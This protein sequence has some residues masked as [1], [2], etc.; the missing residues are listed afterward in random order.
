MICVIVLQITT[1]WQHIE[2]RTIIAG[3]KYKMW[4]WVCYSGPC[5]WWGGRNKTGGGGEWS[6]GGCWHTLGHWDMLHGVHRSP[7]HSPVSGP[8]LRPQTQYH[9]VIMMEMGCSGR[10]DETSILRMF[11]FRTTNN[12]W[13]YVR[14]TTLIDIQFCFATIEHLNKTKAIELLTL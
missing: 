8:A 13:L 2:D 14:P 1:G 6:D 9:L 10:P 5:C 4:V 3:W 12:Q 11:P 7:V